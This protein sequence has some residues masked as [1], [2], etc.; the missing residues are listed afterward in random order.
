MNVPFSKHDGL[1][2]EIPADD[3]A[4]RRDHD[5]AGRGAAGVEARVQ[6]AVGV[7]AGQGRDRFARILKESTHRIS[8]SRLKN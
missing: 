3:A 1:V 5:L 8:Y 6:R 4:G 7:E 2:G